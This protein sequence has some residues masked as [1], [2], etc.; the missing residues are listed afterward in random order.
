MS[1]S[2]PFESEI[3]QTPKSI[4]VQDEHTPFSYQ[5]QT[6]NCSFQHKQSQSDPTTRS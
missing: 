2:F 4:H 3:G 1:N 6:V 5:T